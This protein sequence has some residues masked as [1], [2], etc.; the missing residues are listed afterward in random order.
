VCLFDP[1]IDLVY[2]GYLIMDG[3]DFFEV[4]AV[5]EDGGASDEGDLL[6]DFELDHVFLI[7]KFN[8]VDKM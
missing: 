7:L 4:V 2:D 1:F 3:A 6:I 8:L 5:D